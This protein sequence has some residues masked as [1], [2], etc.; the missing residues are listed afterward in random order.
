[1]RF[2]EIARFA[3]FATLFA[4]ACQTLLLDSA[5][6]ADGF[7]P[8]APGYKG[9]KGTTLY[10]SKLGDNSN[11]SSWEKAFHTIQAA[12]NAVPDDKGGHQ[13]VLRPDTYLEHDI[14]G[15]FKGARGAYNLLVG[16]RDGRYGSGA[17]GWAIIDSS[18]PEKGFKALDYWGTLN[19]TPT[20]SPDEWDRW[21]FRDL[22]TTGAEGFGWDIGS[23]APGSKFTA[24][25]DNC[26]SIGR[27]SGVMVAGHTSR[28]DEPIL[29]RNCHFRSLD[30]WGDAGGAYFRAHNP[31]MP[32]WPDAIFENCTLVAPDNA[33]QVG[34]P[35]FKGY[36][37]LKFKDCNLIVTNFSQPRGTPSTGV[38]SCD[39][40]GEFLHIDFEDCTL[41]GF[42][43]FG[44]S[45]AKITKVEA[46]VKKP[47][48][49]TTK[50]K[51]RAYVE[52]EQS[53]PRGF[54]RLGTWPVEVFQDVL[55]PRFHNEVAA[56]PG[57]KIQL[58]NG[59]NLDGWDF[60][61]VDPKVGMNDV[62]SVSDGSLVCKGEPMG[63]LHTKN[64]YTS[65]KLVVEWRWAPG[66]KPGNSGV[67]MRVNGKPSALPRSLEAQLQHNSAGDFYGF[68]GMKIAGDPERSREAEGAIIGKLR[69]VRRMETNEK[70]P[71]EWN[72]Y[73]ITLDGGNLTALVNGK[74]VNEARDC[75][76]RPGFVGLQSE[77]GE[78]HFRKVELTPIE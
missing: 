50:G 49:Y 39:L 4:F 68:H 71:G 75:Q 22:Y 58:F 6:S 9:R 25:V 72:V 76:V 17:T 35:T 73:E 18:D 34:Y 38:I 20:D 12:A 1:M 65:Y 52:F 62:W 26:V 61:L 47:F 11:G 55:H 40:E 32:T 74:K 28:E 8:A 29:F 36:T 43:T 41:M 33:L 67:L 10:V 64:S 48:S 31:S 2:L 53:V 46:G 16:D 3:S 59:K 57:A 51:C 70:P 45:T 44:F 63:Y 78:I 7:D 21:I 77:G 30:W 37:R 66:K 13:I 15:A 54:E 5:L 42:K 27:F 19:T 60:F 56:A 69:G 24:V 14:V 23:S